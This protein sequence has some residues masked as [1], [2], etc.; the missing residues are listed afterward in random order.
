MSHKGRDESGKTLNARDEAVLK[1][2]EKRNRLVRENE[3]YRHEVKEMRR[4]GKYEL[5]WMFGK[6]DGGVDYFV[7]GF[8][9][10]AIL[11]GDYI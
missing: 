3:R 6:G 11:H 10:R 2:M 7:E 9:L 8:L 5:Q 1:G 4:L